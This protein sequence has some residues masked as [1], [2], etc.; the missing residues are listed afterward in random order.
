VGVPVAVANYVPVDTGGRWQGR[1]G[2]SMRYYAQRPGRDLDELRAEWEARGAERRVFGRT[3]VTAD[4]EKIP[5]AEAQDRFQKALE[6]RRDAWREQRALE[7]AERHAARDE[8]FEG[9]CERFL[10]GE[11][12]KSSKLSP[13]RREQLVARWRH[14][15]AARE[16]LPDPAFRIYRVVLSTSWAAIDG[17]DISHVLG[18]ALGGAVGAAGAIATRATTQALRDAQTHALRLVEREDERRQ[19]EAE[20]QQRAEAR[21]E[22]RDTARQARGKERHQQRADDRFTRHFTHPGWLAVEHKNTAHPHWHVVALSDR[23]LD[24][25]DLNAMRERLGERER[26]R[27]LEQDPQRHRQQAQERSPDRGW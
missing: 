21:Q 16:H 4:G 27:E 19:Q 20:R 3:F 25:A 8:A 11:N 26:A 5:L 22:Q 15:K 24:V 13:E 10:A 18:T 7:R 23:R 14:T 12:S 17:R 1:I 6:E 9:R 2:A